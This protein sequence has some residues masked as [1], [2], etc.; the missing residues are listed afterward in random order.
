MHLTLLILVLIF[1]FPFIIMCHAL[2]CC[3][4]FCLPLCAFKNKKNRHCLH[5]LLTTWGLLTPSPTPTTPFPLTPAPHHLPHQGGRAGRNIPPP[6]VYP[7]PFTGMPSLPIMG[8]F[9]FMWQRLEGGRTGRTGRRH[10]Q[11]RKL[12][13]TL[14]GDTVLFGKGTAAHLLV[15]WEQGGIT[16]HLPPPSS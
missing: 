11:Q 2:C 13:L 7:V 1:L 5:L 10:L 15:L 16:T 12:R 8:H 3:H 14:L 9:F 4:A 6:S